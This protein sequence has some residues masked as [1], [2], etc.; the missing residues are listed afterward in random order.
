MNLLN[1]L[2]QEVRSKTNLKANSEPFSS[3][4]P[5]TKMSQKT[6]IK[7]AEISSNDKPIPERKP[8][9]IEV[10]KYMTEITRY[11]DGRE[12]IKCY[13]VG[14]SK[15]NFAKKKAKKKNLEEVNMTECQ[16]EVY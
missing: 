2:N 12:F 14:K 5:N 1:Q 3:S 13:R 10:I 9:K 6:P 7:Q 11:P 15:K 4:L 16:E 8:I